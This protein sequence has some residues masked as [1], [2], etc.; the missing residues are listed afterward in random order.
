MKIAL[1]VTAIAA[2]AAGAAYCL[3]KAATIVVNGIK[4]FRERVR[5]AEVYFNEADDDCGYWP[6]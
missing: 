6:M 1:K 2:L 4:E 3:Y 5:E